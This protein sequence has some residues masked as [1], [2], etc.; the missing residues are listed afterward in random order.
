MENTATYYK[1]Q[2]EFRI[3]AASTFSDLVVLKKKGEEKA[4]NEL[5]L[6]TLPQIKR[7]I[8]KR[9]AT[10]L[11]KGNLPHGKYRPDDFVDQLFITA[12]NH[13]DEVKNQKD[14][15]PWLFKIADQLLE[16]TIVEEEFDEVF[17]QNIDDF[18][19]PAW[20]A[21]EE[22]FSTDGDGDLVMMD[23]LD[24]ISYRNAPYV[25]NHVFVEDD[26]NEMIAKL[27][28]ELGEE[29]IRRHT[30]MVLYHLPLPMRTVFE[31]ATQFHLTAEEIAMIRGQ[32]LEEVQKLLK[33]A[34]NALETSFYT[35]YRGINY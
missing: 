24:D 2:K 17:F 25:L 23:E 5:L 8:T 16:D 10:A 34:R 20:D 1:K 18:T 19:K 7:Y 12:Y 3:F 9:L 29:N 4:F 31:M 33:N 32:G 14:F 22:K 28:K 30:N 35:R 27:D 26:N 11:S 21:M 13:F 15:Y 6:K